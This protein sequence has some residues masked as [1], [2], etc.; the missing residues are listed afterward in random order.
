MRDRPAPS[1]AHRASGG[2]TVKRPLARVSLALLVWLLPTLALAQQADPAPAEEPAQELSQ[3]DTQPAGDEPGPEELT[4]E[5]A[6]QAFEVPSD[7]DVALAVTPDDLR[8][9]LQPADAGKLAAV[10]TDWMALVSTQDAAYQAARTA[11]EGSELRDDADA[12]GTDRDGLVTRAEVVIELLAEKGGDVDAQREVIRALRESE[13]EQVADVTQG[14]LPQDQTK[15]QAVD[16]EILKAQLRPLTVDQLQK[17]LDAWMVLLQK[18][19]LE[20][21]KAEVASLRATDADEIAKYNAAAVDQRG[22]R[23]SLLKRV[24]AVIDAFEAKGGAEDVVAQQRD[25]VKS[26]VVRPKVTGLRATWATFEAWLFSPEGG[27][28]T[29]LGL[30]RFLLT[31]VGFRLIAFLLSMLL[32]RTL[33]AVGRTPELLRK[34][35]VNT[36]RKGTMVVGLVVALGQLGVDIGP[37]VAAIGGAAF[38]IGFALQGTLSNFAAGLMILMYRP[39]NVGDVVEIGG[40]T[41]KVEGQNM[42]STSIKTFDNKLI[43]VPNNMIWGDVITNATAS[44]TRRVDMTF[45]I[46]YG[47]DMAKAERILREVIDAHPATLD[48]PAPIVQVHELGDSSVNFI[49][50][51]WVATKDYWDVYWDITRAVKERFDAEGVSIPFPQRDVH[52]FHEETAKADDELEG[53]SA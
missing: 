44:N 26:V 6:A 37:L 43:I 3:E 39:Y 41:G 27:I 40:T 9:T 42:V 35:F 19:C 8:D 2:H 38:V 52:V 4:P 29:G 48:D 30:L 17:E 1:A 15:A 14:T 51:P 24:D 5:Q 21:R 50:R 53:A 18:K 25:Y 32:E 34:F 46:G 36:L 13:L 22:E 20:V 23:D 12:L 31:I 7:V 10:L 33:K 16:L 47:D 28:A 49:V 45:G 11:P